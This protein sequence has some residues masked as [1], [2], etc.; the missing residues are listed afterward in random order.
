MRKT[1]DVKTNVK[2]GNLTPDDVEVQ[3]YFGKINHLNDIINP[4]TKSLTCTAQNL[5]TYTFQGT[6]QFIEGGLQGLTLRVLP[7]NP[8][9]ISRPDMFLSK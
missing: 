4:A 5:D 1:I 8:L 7:K 9:L 2:L 6:F 3:V